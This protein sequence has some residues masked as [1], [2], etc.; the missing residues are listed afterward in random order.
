MWRLMDLVDN[1]Y[2]GIY[3]HSLEIGDG[4]IEVDIVNINDFGRGY[5]SIFTPL[6]MPEAFQVDKESKGALP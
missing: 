2:P 6:T 3:M 4:F 1:E 5:K